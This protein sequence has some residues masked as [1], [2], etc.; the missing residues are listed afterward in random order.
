MCYKSVV[1]SLPVVKLIIVSVSIKDDL[2]FPGLISRNCFIAACKI[3]CRNT[4]I[5]VVAQVQ[6]ICGGYLIQQL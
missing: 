6:H 3:L 2:R 5:G 1:S 4:A